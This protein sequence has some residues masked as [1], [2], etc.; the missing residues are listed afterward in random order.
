MWNGPAAQYFNSQLLVTIQMSELT[1]VHDIGTLLS[2][3][4]TSDQLQN[5]FITL[6]LQDIQYMKNVS[7]SELR[8]EPFSTKM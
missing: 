1:L 7:H 6:H 4:E 3:D 8:T 2:I 5:P